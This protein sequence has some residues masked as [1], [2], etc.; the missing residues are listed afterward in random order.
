M[1]SDPRFKRPGLILAAVCLA[2]FAINIDTTVVNVALPSL[3]RQLGASTRDLQ[4]IVD[5]YNLAFAALVLGAGSLGDRFGRRPALVAGLL[6][7]AVASAAGALCTD[8]GQLIAA[9][10]VMG[11]FAAL[12]FPTTLSVITNTFADRGERAKAVGIWGAVV[13]L[14]VA[15]GPVVGGLLLSGFQWPS[16]FVG[17]VPVALLAAAVVWRV[18]PESRDP[19]APPIDRSGLAS[20][21]VAVS[22]LVYTIIEAPGRGWLSGPSVAGYAIALAVAG[23]FVAIERRREHPMIDVS[24]FRN[25]AFSAASASVSVAF[26]ALFGFIFLITQYMQFV[27]GYGTLSTGARIL[28]VALSIGA[29]SVLGANLAGRLGTRRIVVA[30]LTLLGGSFLW[31]SQIGTAIPYEVVIVQM[32]MMGT[33]LGLTTAPATESILSVLP[34]AKAGV[35]SA[36]NDATREAGG[37]LGVAVI[38]SVFTSLYASGVATSGAAPHLSRAVLHLAQSSV[39]AGYAVAAHVP[40]ALHAPVLR[41]VQGAFMNGLHAGCIVAAAVCAAGALGASALPGRSPRR[42]GAASAV[43]GLAAPAEGR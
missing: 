17:L 39:G 15:V 13:G 43:S 3:S 19:L 4:W 24:L 42:S 1:P 25:R 7:F 22:V 8:P 26:F 37:T 21:T 11:A 35:G 29:A 14:G 30:G 18:V 10:V 2:A 12:I 40:L 34:P 33:G 28:P 5:G 41:S 31:I 38:G 9:R 27:R 23:A 36:V 6:G 16:V 20:A 32:V